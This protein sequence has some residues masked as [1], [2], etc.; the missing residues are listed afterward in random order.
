MTD[1]DETGE[2][3]TRTLGILVAVMV[4]IGVVA[5]VLTLVGH[6]G[7]TGQAA[8]QPSGSQVGHQTS[9]APASSTAP[10]SATSATSS[11]AAVPTTARPSSRAPSSATSAA[12]ATPTRTSTAAAATKVVRY[13]VR[14]GD[15][16][17]LIAGWFHQRGYGLVYDWNRSVI[18]RDPDLIFPGQTI[19]VSL[20]GDR[21]T[22]QTGRR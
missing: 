10:S 19:I 4:A 1:A 22:V 12:P 18:G 17:T 3:R 11:T 21:M 5:L 6:G 14:R 8:S 20:K 15:N 9:A 7:S 13:T 2:A 16:L